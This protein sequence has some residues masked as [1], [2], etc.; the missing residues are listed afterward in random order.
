LGVILIKVEVQRLTAKLEQQ[1]A[2]AVAPQNSDLGPFG[3]NLVV[4][5]TAEIP[6]QI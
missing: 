2:P 1:L 5:F 3:F 6:S 4:F